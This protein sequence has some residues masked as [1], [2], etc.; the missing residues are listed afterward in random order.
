[1]LKLVIISFSAGSVKVFDR[2]PP[3]KCNCFST[4]ATNL[5]MLK[6]PYKLNTGLVQYSDPTCSTWTH[7]FKIDPQFQFCQFKVVDTKISSSSS[8]VTLVSLA[9]NL[10]PDVNTITRGVHGNFLGGGGQITFNRPKDYYN[11]KKAPKSQ[12]KIVGGINVTEGSALW[13]RN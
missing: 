2:I 12:N 10:C 13:V 11:T 7:L 4:K 9:I 8:L 5:T 3:H 1:M 6:D